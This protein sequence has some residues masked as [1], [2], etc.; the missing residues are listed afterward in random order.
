MHAIKTLSPED[1][2]AF[3]LQVVVLLAFAHV[4]GELM[5][6]FRQPALIGNI[7]GGMLLGPSVLGHWFPAL[8]QAI[9]RPEQSQ[10]DM[11]AAITW[12]GLL[13]FLMEAGFEVRL[14][15]L[16]RNAASCVIVS[17]GGL[18][19]PMIGGYLL[20]QYLPAAMLTHPDDRLVL[21]LFLAVAM[22]IS[23]LPPL[24]M[25]LRDKDMLRENVGQ[26]SLGAAMMD[27]V[28][29]W[30]LV[31]ITTSLHVSGT[32]SAVSVVKSAGAAVLFLAGC[33]LIGRPL[34]RR[35]I[36]WHNSVAPGP[37]PQLSLLIICGLAGSL[38]T[39]WLGL[40]SI[41]G[42]F[43]VGILFGSAS[44][45]QKNAVHSLSLVVS[46]FLA[47]LYFGLA[48]LRL[49]IWSVYE[50]NMGMLLFTVIAVACIGKLLGVYLGAWA[51]GLPRWERLAMGFGMNARGGT[52]IIIATLG[53]SIGLLTREMFSIIVV[54]AI[55]TV[56]LSGPTM[57]WALSK[58]HRDDKTVDAALPQFIYEEALEEPP[59]A[60]NLVE[61]EELRLA[62]RLKSY[63]HAMR[64]DASSPA[65][66]A[67]AGIHEPFVAVASMAEQFLQQLATQSLCPLTSARLIS[68]ENR[69]RLLRYIEESVRSL[70]TSSVKMS[71]DSG[72]RRHLDSYTEGLDFL[73]DRMLE[74]LTLKD[75]AAAEAF[76]TLTEGRSEILEG[77]RSDYLRSA[78]DSDAAD[79]AVLFEVAHGFEQTM[80]MLHRFALLLPQA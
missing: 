34:L 12:V 68:L 63:T 26:I 15:L 6:R 13:L 48:G 46:S 55:V 7:F 45:L 39:S 49:N 24:A 5:R 40:E 19:V 4:G 42:I 65:R 72:L 69:L 33:F 74:A 38:I 10:A 53:L 44:G 20:G 8:Q 23:A 25:I 32:F 50:A 64:T 17:A 3:L 2:A 78:A 52:E 80:W 35:F 62:R 60:L 76:V 18:I 28:V 59:V 70:F 37:A 36:D 57:A 51:C 56:I 54:M 75:A 47:P 41:L 22:S 14:D 73:L 27:D 9:F 58:V 67:A 16:R 30:I 29:A 11:L 66:E 71:A 61:E 21:S 77:V 79:Q 31:G 1:V 43:V